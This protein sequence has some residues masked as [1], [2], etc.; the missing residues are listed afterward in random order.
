[1]KKLFSYLFAIIIAFVAAACTAENPVLQIEGGKVKGVLSETESV[2]VYR[3]IPYA[4]PPVG[5]LRWKAPH[6]VRP[7]E[8]VFIADKFGNPCYQAAHKEGDFYSKEFFF[9]GDPPLSEDCL[10]LNVW[11]PSPGKLQEKLPVALWVHGGAYVAGWGHEPEMDGEAWAKKGVIL[12]TFNY[13]LG[14]FGFL[15][16]PE[17]S[18]ENPD[19]VSGNY[20]TLDQIAALRWIKS[21]IAQFGGDPENITVFGQSAGA[22]SIKQLV[23]SPLSKDMISKAIIMSGGGVSTQNTIMASADLKDAEVR[24]KEILDWGG[25][26]DLTKMRKASTE[27]IFGAV[28]AYGDSIKQWVRFGPVIDGHVLSMSFN[29]AA[30]SGKIADVPYMI[31]FTMDDII[32]LAKTEEIAAF[33]DLREAQGGNCYAYQF[34]RP[35]PGDKSGAFHSSELWFVF[36]TLSRSWRPFTKGDQALSDVMTD[37]WTNFAK[38]GHPNGES[39]GGWSAY[40]KENPRFMIFK[41]D[42]D[43]NEASEMGEP[44][45]RSVE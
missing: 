28:R 43:D 31:G 5:D 14:I 22:N 20:G 35:L 33:C 32:P 23:T 29:D 45:P 6:A 21:N 4:A 37:A 10:C 27:E 24:G 3:G 40:T 13:R 38:Y 19:H 18:I 15:A 9:N 34:A 30:F 17:L 11:T 1:M 26:K 7:W 16:H 2:Y 8:G 36:N 39:Q 25:F 12:V 42:G 44:L 41:L